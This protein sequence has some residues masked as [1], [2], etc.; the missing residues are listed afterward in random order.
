M[1]NELIY[2]SPVTNYLQGRQTAQQN[3]LANLQLQSGQFQM[4]QAQ[5]QSSREDQFRNALS[6][7]LKG[8]PDALAQL[9]EADPE[10]ALQ[11]Q[12]QLN[13]LK[14]AQQV[15]KAKEA[16]IQARG[17]LSSK[18]PAQYMKILLPQV[19]EQW[20]AHHGKAPE[21]MTDAD[22][23]ELARETAAQA[24]AV[25]GI[26][27]KTEVKDLGDKLV[28]I[29]ETGQVLSE[30]P[31]AATPG[32][33]LSS[34][35][36]RRGQDL[37]NAREKEKNAQGGQQNQNQIQT[38]IAKLRDDYSQT[39]RSTGWFDQQGFYQRL[40]TVGSDATGASD[41]ALVFSFMKVLDPTSAVR[42]GE[43]ANAQNT[44]GIP[45]KIVAQ[46]NKVLE[47]AFLSPRQRTEFIKSAD[48]IYSTAYKR[49]EA[50]KKD[51]T[52]KATRA[53]MN[54]Q[55]VIVDYGAPAPE[56]APAQAADMPADITALLKKHGGK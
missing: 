22:A 25:A 50:I 13:Q 42:E 54:P 17:V 39:V 30:Q 37:T 2:A 14:Q 12:T 11:T 48:K 16:Y 20:V 32:E 36:T 43:Y 55:D 19:I 29:D 53:G 38:N 4:Q 45:G 46:Y 9:Y 52:G 51:Y 6:A 15:E 1:A 56:G 8:G 40:K 21:D 23:L 18:A 26:V 34:D 5:D 33:K 7:Y 44:A 49:Q 35:T 3:Q 41:L 31:K 47:G 27:P 24:G 10:R 28:T